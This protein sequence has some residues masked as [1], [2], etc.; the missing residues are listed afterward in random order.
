MKLRLFIRRPAYGVAGVA[1]LEKAGADR[2]APAG[3]R[4]RSIINAK[5][6]TE[7]S[8]QVLGGTEII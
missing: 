1:A 4:S 5:R 8:Y 7:A 2:A 3:L 6:N